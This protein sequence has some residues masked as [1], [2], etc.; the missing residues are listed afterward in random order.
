MYMSSIPLLDPNFRDLGK[1]KKRSKARLD[2]T[3]LQGSF[4]L[5]KGEF[6]GWIYEPFSGPNFHSA[7]MKFSSGPLALLLISDGPPG[8]FQAS[9]QFI[10]FDASNCLV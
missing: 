8:V 6:E 3:V 1:P 7:D 5:E 10:Y 9:T 2:G 4:G